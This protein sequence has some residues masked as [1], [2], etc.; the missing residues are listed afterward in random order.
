MKSFESL[1][2]PETRVALAEHERLLATVSRCVPAQAARH[3]VHC[4]L[5]DGR[6]RLVLDNASWVAKLRFGERQLLRALVAG[7]TRVRQVSW[8]VA[9]HDPRPELDAL[10]RRGGAPR[11][12]VRA[13]P[14]S[15]AHVASVADALPDDELQ[16][17]LRALAASMAR[18]AGRGPDDGPGRP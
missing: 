6:L 17:A 13:P 16:R 15:A 18:R 9:P 8:H 3:L 14:R 5:V 10:R 11:R 7:G 2:G 12:F 4:R 1:I